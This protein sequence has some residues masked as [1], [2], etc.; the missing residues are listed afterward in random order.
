G[1][2]LLYDAASKNQL[3]KI[4]ELVTTGIDPNASTGNEGDQGTAL[5]TASSKGHLETVKLLLSHGADPNA[6]GGRFGNALQVTSIHNTPTHTEIAKLLISQGADL[7]KRASSGCYHANEKELVRILLEHSADPNISHGMFGHAL[8]AAADGEG[9]DDIIELLIDHY[10]ADVNLIGG[11]YGTALQVASEAGSAIVV[12]GA[13]PNA[14][15]AG[16]HSTAL[17][18]AAYRGFRRIVEI[19]LEHGADVDT[20]GGASGNAIQA[21]ME[22][23]DGPNLE[24]A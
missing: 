9:N 3:D 22:G 1:A 11:T 19:L 8:Q 16:F 24:L 4:E 18:A 10:G 5:Y 20:Q 13:D 7:W 6:R 14:P 23:Y 21:A 12:K 17:Q 15:V 2:S